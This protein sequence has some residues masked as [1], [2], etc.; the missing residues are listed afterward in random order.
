[1][2]RFAIFI[3]VFFLLFILIGCDGRNGKETVNIVRYDKVQYEY[4]EFDSYSALKQM[5]KE[6][7]P[8]SKLLVE[9][10]LEIG[11]IEDPHIETKFKDYF[12]DSLLM[13][14]NNDVEEKFADLTPYEEEFGIAFTALKKHFPDIKVPTVYAQLSA[15]NESVIVDGDLLGVSLDKYMG[16]DYP[17]Y[18]N[19]YYN[20]QRKSMIP[21]RI[22]LDCVYAYM[23]SIYPFPETAHHDLCS[24]I[25][26]YGIIN[27]IIADLS[28]YPQARLMN[29]TK[30]EEKWCKDNESD[31]LKFMLLNSHLYSS[32]FMVVRKYVKASPYTTFFGKGS[33]DRIG[34]WVGLR[35]VESFMK[36]NKNV[37]YQELMAMDY[38]DI[39][40][41]SKYLE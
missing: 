10:I 35:I 33:P 9:E 16:K 14:L 11:S 27:N 39:L 32:N 23:Q 29:Y 2:K 22:V 20:Y 8:M 1:M 28:G 4:V 6:Y 7:R 41:K 3:S 30:E 31:I 34:L 12:R 36:N 37:S 21:E 19:F 38:Y 40:A 26:Y 5:Q 24:I 25:I 18:S 13:K 17:L 15:L